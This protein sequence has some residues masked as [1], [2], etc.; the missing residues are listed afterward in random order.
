MKSHRGRTITAT[1]VVAALCALAPAAQ[2]NSLLSGYG[3]PGQGSQVIL[4]ATLV[5]GGGGASGSG[6]GGGTSAGGGGGSSQGPAGA[7]TG[8]AEGSS[9][10]SSHAPTGSR[11]AAGGAGGGHASSSDAR[12]YSSA[13]LLAAH[14]PAA[15]SSP[16]GLSGTDLL[17]ILLVLGGL[18]LTGVLTRRVAG[19]PQ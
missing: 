4:G 8:A 1:L 9:G 12:A 11:H 14:E 2:A 3:G 15:D 17:F 7:S 6:S 10:G 5:G 13:A 16:F 19:R 18:V